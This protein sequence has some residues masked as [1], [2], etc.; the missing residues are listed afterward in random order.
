MIRT[1]LVSV[2]HT[3]ACT[4]TA[5]RGAERTD[6]LERSLLDALGDDPDESSSSVHIGPFL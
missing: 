1:G 4:D 3:A 2:A 5:H 6:E